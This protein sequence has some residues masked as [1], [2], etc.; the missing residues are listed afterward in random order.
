MTPPGDRAAL[1]RLLGGPEMGW[2]LDRLPRR[3]LTTPDRRLEGI[4]L[5]RDPDAAQRDGA[6]RLVG[7][8]RRPGA[9]LR[10]DL[11]EVEE[12]LRRGPWP[13]GLADAVETLRGPVVDRRVERELEAVAWE[14]SRVGLMGPAARFPGLPEW[15]QEWCRNGGLK[16]LTRAEAERRGIDS[17]P[18]LGARLVSDAATVLDSLPASGE[19]LA[20][21]AR[22][23]VGDAHGL[24]S[25]RPLGRLAAA[26]VAA[27]FESEAT[28]D[29]PEHRS[30]RDAWSCAGVVMSNVASTVLSVGVP[31]LRS[32][33]RGVLA[34]A[35]GQV[36]EAMRAA[37]APVLLTLDQVRSG[38]VPPL[39]RTAVVHVCENPTIIEVV[40]ARWV[41]DPRPDAAS[42]GAGPVL[43]CTWGQPS[44]AVVE[45]L[46]RLIAEGAQC[47]YH[48]DFDWAGLR[49]ATSLRSR[50][51]WVP[52]R[53]SATDYRAAVAD[54]APSLR[55][56]GTPVDAPWDAGLAEAMREHGLAVEEEGVAEL[57]AADVLA[58]A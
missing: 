10:I 39:P 34:A 48:G 5:L 54:A 16:R 22:R 27:A 38:G 53:Y 1:D 45:L 35:T 3:I 56:T 30:V 4:V 49:I 17:S 37:R 24:D 7:M 15:W 25:S 21:L 40:A 29:G 46:R 57:M 20:I 2:F 33:D 31:G 42:S 6:V 8:S 32:F 19:P 50:V 13:A 12:I 11:G 41:E 23:V 58:G 43:V 51:P 36:L 47:R 55:L 18:A 14:R 44:A 52:W 9:G 26:V 28:P